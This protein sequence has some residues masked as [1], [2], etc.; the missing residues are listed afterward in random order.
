MGT[1]ARRSKLYAYMGGSVIGART[2]SFYAPAI[3]SILPQPF[4]LPGGL[5][6]RMAVSIGGMGSRWGAGMMVAVP[7]VPRDFAQARLLIFGVALVPV[8]L[9]RP[10]GVWRE[11]EVGLLALVRRSWDGMRFGGRGAARPGGD[12]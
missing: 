11:N 4:G 2:G 1:K 10:Q 12:G 7:E 8:M 3:I 5:L 9:L 6:A